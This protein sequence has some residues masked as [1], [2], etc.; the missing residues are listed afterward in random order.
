MFFGDLAIV[1]FARD[2]GCCDLLEVV[3]KGFVIQEDP[4]VVVV[5]VES[6]LNLTYR[7]CNFPNVGVSCERYECRIDPLSRSWR[8]KRIQSCL[9]RIRGYWCSR[10]LRLVECIWNLVESS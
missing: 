1:G 2:K 4:V 8:R 6:I 7:S 5:P 10:R 3:V 9:C